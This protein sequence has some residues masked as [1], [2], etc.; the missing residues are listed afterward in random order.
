MKK[1]FLYILA[2][3][4]LFF[5]SCSSDDDVAGP[6]NKLTE[7]LDKTVTI[8]LAA[9][10][11]ITVDGTRANPNPNVGAIDTVTTD[12][13]QLHN[14]CFVF[15]DGNTPSSKIVSYQDVN[16]ETLTPVNGIY[17]KRVSTTSKAVYAVALAN[18]TENY[19]SECA[20]YEDVMNTK[21]DIRSTG[22]TDGRYSQYQAL[23]GRQYKTGLPMFAKA[24]V[25][26]DAVYFN[27]ERKVARIRVNVM[28]DFSARTDGASFY[29]REIYMHNFPS[30]CVWDAKS[31]C[32]S[33][34]NTAESVNIGNDYIIMSTGDYDYNATMNVH[35][36]GWAVFYTLPWE[37]N[38]TI[39][40]KTRAPDIQVVVKG[41]YTNLDGTSTIYYPVLLNGGILKQNN[42]YVINIT[43]KGKGVE[44][45]DVNDGPLNSS[46]QLSVN[47]QVVN[48]NEVNDFNKTI[49]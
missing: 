11:L 7:E 30:K 31:G 20:T 21:A 22:T 37:D 18:V 19:V 46:S 23:A 40:G 4:P 25:A 43:I 32:D 28:T 45:K 10:D 9:K 47:V 6:G 36:Q 29:P 42:A 13:N 44:Q 39:N 41:N 15:F 12:D 16:F 24:A 27:L 48:W 33:I 5:A 35:Y 17:T 3:M 2:L 1:Q 38:I 49:E 14:V 8:S 26:N 34:I